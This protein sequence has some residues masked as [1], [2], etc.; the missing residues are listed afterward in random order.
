[1][2]GLREIDETRHLLYINNSANDGVSFENGSNSS[3]TNSGLIT[4]SR[5]GVETDVSATNITLT[6]LAGGTIIGRNGSG[7]G[8]DATS[9]VVTNITAFGAFVDV[10]VHQDGLVHISELA[11]TFVKDPHAVV[12]VGDRRQ[13]RVL[14]VDLERQRISLS[15]RSSAAPKRPGS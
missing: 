5:H 4:A 3:L 14:S 1:M 2:K 6:N 7:F 15:A 8:S 12:K 10:G 11:D 9:A 13:V